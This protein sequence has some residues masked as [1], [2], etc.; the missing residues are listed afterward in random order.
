MKKSVAN[1]RLYAVEINRN[2]ETWKNACVFEPKSTSPDPKL[3][4]AA[5]LTGR[6]ARCTAVSILCLAQSSFF[7]TAAP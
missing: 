7:G 2:T 3:D 1:R 6:V 5:I 4:A